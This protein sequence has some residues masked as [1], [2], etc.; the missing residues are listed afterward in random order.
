MTTDRRENDMGNRI[1]LLR[2]AEEGQP[3]VRYR[4]GSSA[5][6]T[7]SIFVDVFLQ[8]VFSRPSIWITEVSTYLFSS[9]TTTAP[10]QV[11]THIKVTFLLDYL[12]RPGGSST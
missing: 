9:S 2:G 11:G 4:G 12:A 7:L 8:Y 5:L 10:L 1:D 3:P 6:V